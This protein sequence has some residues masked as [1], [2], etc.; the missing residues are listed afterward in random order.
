M[1]QI[2]CYFLYLGDSPSISLGDSP[3]ISLTDSVADNQ[4]T[5]WEMVQT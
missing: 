2:N 3:S 5:A 1:D 4:S